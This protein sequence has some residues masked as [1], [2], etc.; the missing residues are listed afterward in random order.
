MPC[1]G[2][3]PTRTV[4]WSLA[5]GEAVA[6]G[7]TLSGRGHLCPSSGHDEEHDRSP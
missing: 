4:A 6:A 2:A 1:R 5:V 3:L 7:W